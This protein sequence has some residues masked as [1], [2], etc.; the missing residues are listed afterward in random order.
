M[1]L[2]ENTPKLSD[3]SVDDF[4]AIV[5]AGGQAPMFT[6]KEEKT[7]HK[8][9]VEF[10]TSGKIAASLCHGTSLLIYAKTDNGRYIIK[11]KTITGFTNEEEDYVDKSM[12]IKVMPFRIEDEVKSLGARFIKRDPFTPFAVQDGNLITGQQQNS[13][14]FVAD[15]IIDY[16]N[17]KKYLKIKLL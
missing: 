17:K 3:F 12:G 13:G 6:F 11:G 7:L 5:V 14:K 4:D 2:L 8:L 9:F 15:L 10:Y 1:K 16:F